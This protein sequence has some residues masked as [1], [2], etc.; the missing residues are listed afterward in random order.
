M[1][2]PRRCEG[3]RPYPH[4]K[5]LS[6]FGPTGEY[7][8]AEDIRRCSQ[9]SGGSA[10]PDRV[11]RSRNFVLNSH[12]ISHPTGP[13]R[14]SRK[15]CLGWDRTCHVYRYLWIPC[16][17]WTWI[18]SFNWARIPQRLVRGWRCIWTAAKSA[19]PTKHFGT[20]SVSKSRGLGST[21]ASDA[22]A[23]GG[24]RP[25]MIY[26]INIDQNRG[27]F[28]Y[29][30]L[31]DE[32]SALGLWSRY[33][34]T[35]WLLATSLPIEEVSRRLI[36]HISQATDR[37]LVTRLVLPYQGWLPTEAWAWVNN[38]YPLWG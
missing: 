20:S 33:M 24:T 8:F 12:H 26:V 23:W 27:G 11:G 28:N 30:P 1:N 10:E 5:L 32:M 3:L 29:Q 18:A 21:S 6:Y 9:G 22:G 19:A 17:Q 34:N 16:L 31:Y 35:T 2:V 7:G 15:I 14:P 37:L 38:V 25:K 13:D 4:D 36:T